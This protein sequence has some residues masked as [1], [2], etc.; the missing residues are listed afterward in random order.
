M[1]KPRGGNAGS[2][3]VNLQYDVRHGFQ[4]PGRP[5]EEAAW[6]QNIQKERRLKEQHGRPR[7]PGTAG[8]P[9][10]TRVWSAG[11]DSTAPYYEDGDAWKQEL[12]RRDPNEASRFHSTQRSKPAAF[13]RMPTE[14]I[15]DVQRR[16]GDELERRQWQKAVGDFNTTELANLSDLL[17]DKIAQRQEAAYFAQNRI[18][19]APPP[20][21]RPPWAQD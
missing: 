13:A 10:G 11:S 18:Q 20:G 2:G 15:R 17:G 21:V 8:A 12:L 14:E 5:Q 4:R 1:S 9:G 6:A 16:A 19:P 3:G 7:R